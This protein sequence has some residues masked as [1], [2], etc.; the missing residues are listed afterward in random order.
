M[1]QTVNTRGGQI[2]PSRRVCM[3]ALSPIIQDTLAN[4]LS[5]LN[6]GLAVVYIAVR[7]FI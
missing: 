3:Q 6:A 2:H 5:T 7:F 4:Y 1:Q